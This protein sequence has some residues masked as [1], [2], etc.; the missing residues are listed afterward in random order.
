MKRWNSIFDIM[1]F[2]IKLLLLAFI[3]VEFGKIITDKSVNIFYSLDNVYIKFLSQSLIQIGQAVISNFPL[4]V[5]VRIAS[6]RNKSGTPVMIGIIGYISFLVFTMIF[7]YGILSPY[8]T[9]EVFGIQMARVASDGSQSLILPIQTGLLGALVVGF[10]TRY[11]YVRSRRRNPYSIFAFLD[12]DTVGYIYN[13]IFC[14]LAGIAVAIFWP[15]LLNFLQKIIVVISSNIND[16]KRMFV[17]GALEKVL[18]VLGLGELIRQPFWF[19]SAG[20]SINT[21]TGETILGDVGIFSKLQELNLSTSGYGRFITPYYIV[22]MFVM[23]AMI[24]ALFRSE[25]RKSNRSKFFVPVLLLVF[26]LFVN[27]NALPI[28]MFLLFSAPLLFGIHVLFSG[29]LFGLLEYLDIFLGFSYAGNTTFASPG[30]FLDYIILLRN[31]DYQKTLLKIV[32]IG[33]IFA[34][35]YYFITRIYIKYLAFDA[36]SSGKKEHYAINIIDSIGGCDNIG[37]IYSNPFRLAIVVK[38]Q[39]LIDFE[40]IKKLNFSKIAET[41]EGIIIYSGMSSAILRSEILK[42]IEVSKRN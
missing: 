15:Y 6:R 25:N 17:Y 4:I 34:L 23:P 3:F 28:E 16:P 8:A 32:F 26:F 19:G 35:I 38:D 42:A 14:G 41:S 21:I 40:K 31:P 1:R 30:S 33:L 18:N 11:S 5:I 29:L 37:D 7:Q 39:Q 9:Y 36:I 20:G 12:K 24:L 22:N 27:G 10:I 2:P 13:I